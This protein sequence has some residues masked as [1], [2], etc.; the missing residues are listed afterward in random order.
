MKEQL[1]KLFS[2]RNERKQNSTEIQSTEKMK[3]EQFRTHVIE[4]INTIFLPVF[5]EF[6]S[7]LKS[8]GHEFS[9]A[10]SLE[11]ASY[12]STQISFRVVDNDSKS[13]YSGS[14]KLS[15]G[16][17]TSEDKFEVGQSLWWSR[18]NE[19]TKLKSSI[20]ID[21]VNSEWVRTQVLNFID[22]VIKKD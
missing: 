6:E 20:I 2:D 3:H 12:P 13:N 21:R 11:N 4:I 8:R 16:T 1:D 14:S 18:G 5:N 10:S 7:E 19:E 15:F 17:T 22:S 9:V